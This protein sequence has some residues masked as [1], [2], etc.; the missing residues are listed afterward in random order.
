MLSRRDLSK[1]EAIVA[2]RVPP[3]P[4][5]MSRTKMRGAAQC[6][7]VGMLAVL[8]GSFW[9]ASALWTMIPGTLLLITAVI[10]LAP[11]W[12]SWWKRWKSH[13]MRKLEDNIRKL[14]GGR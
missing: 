10:L 2:G 8:L 7:A 5:D 13:D 9:P 4:D 12:R 11:F 14:Y 6:S 3:W 1:A